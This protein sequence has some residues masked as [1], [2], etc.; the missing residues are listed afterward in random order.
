[1][2]LTI[3]DIIERL[4]LAPSTISKVINNKGKVSK[5]TRARY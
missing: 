4:G 1:M 5:E 3:Y 2:K